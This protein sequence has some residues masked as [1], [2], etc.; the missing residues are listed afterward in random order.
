MP[1]AFAFLNYKDSL[2]SVSFPRFSYITT[3][4]GSYK[5]AGTATNCTLDILPWKAFASL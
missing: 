2:K 1:S 5:I 4:F 3:S